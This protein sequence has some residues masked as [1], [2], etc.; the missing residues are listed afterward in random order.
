MPAIQE[1]RGTGAGVGGR[2]TKTRDAIYFMVFMQ[3]TN[4]DSVPGIVAGPEKR[5]VDKEHKPSEPWSLLYFR[6][7]LLLEPLSP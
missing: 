7:V 6:A 3:S 2:G 1:V 4:T 5:E